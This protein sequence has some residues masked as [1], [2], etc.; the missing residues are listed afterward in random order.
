MLMECVRAGSR[1]MTV[2]SQ[3][4]LFVLVAVMSINAEHEV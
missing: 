3:V 1:G 4:F 2:R